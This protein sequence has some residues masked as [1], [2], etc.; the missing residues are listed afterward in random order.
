M[1]D[2]AEVE[3]GEVMDEGDDAVNP[4]LGVGHGGGLV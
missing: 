4:A 3:E 1:D 2:D